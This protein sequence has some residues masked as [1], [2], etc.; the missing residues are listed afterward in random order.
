[1]VGRTR[2]AFHL[3]PRPQ[4]P[5]FTP[6]L[7]LIIDRPAGAL[8]PDRQGRG[9]RSDIPACGAGRYRFEPFSITLPCRGSTMAAVRRV[10]RFRRNVNHSPNPRSRT[11]LSSGGE[12]VT[13]HSSAYE[14]DRCLTA[15]SLRLQWIANAEGLYRTVTGSDAAGLFA[16][17]IADLSAEAERLLGPALAQRWWSRSPLGSRRPPTSSVSSRD[18]A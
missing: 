14:T 6:R 13:H 3:L 18:R 4:L 12:K 11:A 8:K 10:G 7:P 2:R 16:D 17:E 1:M 5:A 9:S 15:I